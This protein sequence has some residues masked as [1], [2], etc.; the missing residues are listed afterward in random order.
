MLVEDNKVGG[1]RYWSDEIGG[2]VVVWDTSLVSR[3]MVLL[4]VAEEGP[5]RMAVFAK[6][7][8]VHKDRGDYCF[9]GEVRSVVVKRSG[10]IRYVVENNEGLL[11]ILSEN[12]IK[13]G[14]MPI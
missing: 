7:D 10:A 3:E 6:G 5:E 8:R 4:A 11:L 13:K 9:E 2:G 12:Q 14:A 1:K